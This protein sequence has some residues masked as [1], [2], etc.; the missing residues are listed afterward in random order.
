MRMVLDG[1]LGKWVILTRVSP[2]KSNILKIL[3]WKN[4]FRIRSD[5]PQAYMVILAPKRS[6]FYLVFTLVLSLILEKYGYSTLVTINYKVWE[7]FITFES[8]FTSLQYFGPGSLPP[9]RSFQIN[10][11]GVSSLFIALSQ[12]GWIWLLIGA[13]V[14]DSYVVV[15]AS[16]ENTTD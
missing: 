10:W 4:T 5:F 6:K 1:V 12:R 16:G 9:H 14:I 8:I 13:F 7:Q 15:N 11:C 2:S 3:F